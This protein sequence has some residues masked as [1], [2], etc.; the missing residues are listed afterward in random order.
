[1][2]EGRPVNSS[3]SSPAKETSADYNVRQADLVSEQSTTQHGLFR[4]G[5]LRKDFENYNPL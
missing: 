4:D 2:E 1:M 3:R 5:R